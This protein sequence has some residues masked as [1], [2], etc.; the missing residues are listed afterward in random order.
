MNNLA[1]AVPAAIATGGLA[2]FSILGYARLPRKS[3][4]DIVP[5]AAALV[6]VP[7]FFIAIFAAFAPQFLA[8]FRRH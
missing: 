1:G 5:F 8:I 2:L 3:P 4:R 6:I 7:A